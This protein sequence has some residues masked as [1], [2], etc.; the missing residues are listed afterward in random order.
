MH[1]LTH[2]LGFW[3]EQNRYDRDTY[4]VIHTDNIAAGQ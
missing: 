2:A 4:V 3:H 1:E